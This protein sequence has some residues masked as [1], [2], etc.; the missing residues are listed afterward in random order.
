[1][2]ADGFSRDD[3]YTSVLQG[4][5]IIEDYPSDFPFPS[6]LIYGQTGRQ[7]HV[8]SVWGYNEESQWAVII[9]V[10]R[11]DPEQWIDWRT[12]KPRP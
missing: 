11:L 12:R 3:V 2:A 8:H 6:C 9:T 1:M 7:E 4:S 5:E 10:Y